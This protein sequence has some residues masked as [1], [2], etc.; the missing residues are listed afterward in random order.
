MLREGPVVRAFLGAP[1]DTPPAGDIHIP[2]VHQQRSRTAL[3]FAHDNKEEEEAN[4][5]AAALPTSVPAPASP[6]SGDEATSGNGSSGGKVT[7]GTVTG[8]RVLRVGGLSLDPQEYLLFAG[9]AMGFI[10]EDDRPDTVFKGSRTPAAALLWRHQE[11]RE[12]QIL[13]SH[14]KGSGDAA[15]TPT[16]LERGSATSG[17]AKARRLLL[18]SEGLL[19]QALTVQ[20][21]NPEA[22]GLLG[23]PPA[24]A[25]I[26]TSYTLTHTCSFIYPHHHQ[27]CRGVC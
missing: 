15:A 23:D 17:G 25:L 11:R 9:R 6:P 26:H 3:S 10:D 8:V 20:P 1:V 16:L 22:H 12:V 13:F 24:K 21:L 5:A 2:Q 18:V 4:A 19:R 7:G 27:S 14:R